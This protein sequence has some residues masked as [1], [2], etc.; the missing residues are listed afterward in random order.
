M[1]SGGDNFNYFPENQLTKFFAQCT[2]NSKGKSR[3]KSSTTYID[4]LGR[5][6]GTNDFQYTILHG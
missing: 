6:L 1:T 3:P 5:E 4:V 2:L